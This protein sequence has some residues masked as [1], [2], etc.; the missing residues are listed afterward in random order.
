V[1]GYEYWRECHYAIR[2]GGAEQH[3]AAEVVSDW[4]SRGGQ[5]NGEGEGR[6]LVRPNRRLILEKIST[7]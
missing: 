6:V 5:E 3:D 4:G 2:E 1:Y 7:L